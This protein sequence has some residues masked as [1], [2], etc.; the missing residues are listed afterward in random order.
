MAAPQTDIKSQAIELATKAFGAFSEDISSMFEVDMKCTSKGV[1]T[2]TIKGLSQKFKKLA[3]VNCIK[4]EGILNGT[5]QIVFDKEGL[6]TLAG[7][8]V[9]LPKQRILDDRKRDSIK[10]AEYVA[11][12]IKEAGNLLVG[13]WDR[14]FR[15]EL[16]GH[17]HFT[18]TNTFIG[19]PWDN[20]KANID[21]NEEQFSFV[22]YEMTIGD[23]PSFSCGVIF[24]E[25]IFKTPPPAAAE[26]SAPAEEKVAEKPQEE[27]KAEVV[28]A[29]V[30]EPAA[31]PVSETIQKM[32]QSSAVLPGGTSLSSLAMCAKDIMQKEVL[33]GNSDDS[34][35]QALTKMQQADVGYMMIGTDGLPEGIVSTFDIAATLS[36][37]LRPMF[38]KWRRP[39]DDAT[40]QIKIKWIMTRPVRTI[41]SDASLVSI[42]ESMCQYGLRCLP[43]VE[44]DGKVAGLITVFDVFKAFLHSDSG[45]SPAGNAPQ[46]PP[47]A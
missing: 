33:W 22:P 31:G 19:V 35:Q 38:A 41:K 34:V 23:Y 10:E 7:V 11:D 43:V 14:I 25:A 32:T 26:T 37:Y 20:P 2:E 42:M 13:S 15:E 8:I 6:F 5:F 29:A 45:L 47:L 24:P 3:A 12:A 21:L 16:E 28:P 46:G 17:G 18:Q 36:V 4:S 30:V 44:K 39:T 9:M 40:L 27:A 1:C